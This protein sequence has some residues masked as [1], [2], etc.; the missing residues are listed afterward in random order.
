M[1]KKAELNDL[2]EGNTVYIVLTVLFVA[3]MVFFVSSYKNNAA[4]W[5]DYYAKEIA[6][7]IDLSKP[8]DEIIIDIQ[9]PSEI[10]IKN[11]IRSMSEMIEIDNFEKRV[12]IKLSPGRKSGYGFFNDVDVIVS[13]PEF[14]VPGN[15]IT[16]KIIPSQKSK[17]Q[18][19]EQK[20]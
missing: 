17:V 3:G 5:E 10:A 9:K 6:K 2:L 20:S 1:N 14:G 7:L 4:V 19:D 15:V 8:G 13:K 16:L 12:W 18:N 11:E